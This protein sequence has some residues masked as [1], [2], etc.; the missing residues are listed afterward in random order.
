MSFVNNIDIPLHGPRVIKFQ[1]S[2]FYE[3]KY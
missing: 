2:K 3:M 1:E